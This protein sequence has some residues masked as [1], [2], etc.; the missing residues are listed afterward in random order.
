LDDLPKFYSATSRSSNVEG[1]V[2]RGSL[3]KQIT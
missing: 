1:D 3:C 2:N